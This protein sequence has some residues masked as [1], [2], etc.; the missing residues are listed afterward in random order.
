MGALLLLQE[1]PSLSV[2]STVCTVVMKDVAS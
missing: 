2:L 1:R